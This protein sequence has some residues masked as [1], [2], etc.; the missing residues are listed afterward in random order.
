METLEPENAVNMGVF[1]K[2]NNFVN[3]KGPI[4]I[5]QVLHNNFKL[6]LVLK[7][8]NLK[9]CSVLGLSQIKKA[10]QDDGTNDIDSDYITPGLIDKFNGRLAE[11]VK[12]GKLV[13]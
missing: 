9:E 8:F 10:N 3:R 2:M 12:Y 1:N 5:F 13:R 4:P 11:A 7:N 6:P